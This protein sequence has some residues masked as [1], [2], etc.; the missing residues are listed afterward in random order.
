MYFENTGS[1]LDFQEHVLPDELQLST[2]NAAA[3]FDFQKDGF[4]QAIIGGNFYENNIEMGRYDASFGHILSI[5]KNGEMKI[6]SLGGLN[7]SG[8]V[9]HIVPIQVAERYCFIIAKNDGP[10]QV[11][12]IGGNPEVLVQ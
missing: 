10:M 5:G 9:K 4:K 3:L 6:E 7:I 8:K 12:Q 1:G 2:I 11:L